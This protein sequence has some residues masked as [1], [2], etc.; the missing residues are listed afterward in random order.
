MATANVAHRTSGSRA[1]SCR[2][3]FT[4]LVDLKWHHTLLIF[5]MSFLCSCCSSPWPGGLLAFAHGDL[6][7][8]G[9]V[10]GAGPGAGGERGLRALRDQHPLL[11]LGLPLLHRGPGDHRLRRPHGD[12]GVPAGHPGP[13]RAEHRGADGQRHHAGLHLHEDRPGPPA[14]RDPHLQQARGH[15]RAPRPPL[16]HAAGGR[17]AQEHDHQRHHPHAG[18]PQDHQPRGRVVPLHQV[19]IPME[20]GVGGNSIFLVAPLIIYHVIDSS[21]PS[22]TWRRA[23]CTTTRTWRW[24]S[25]SRAWWRPR[26]SPPRPAPPTWPTRS[27]G[28]GASCPSWPRR[29]GATRSTYSK[30]GNTVKVPT[31]AC[32]ARQLEEN[33]SLLDTLPL[34]SPK[35]QLRK[36]SVAGARAKPRFSIAPDSS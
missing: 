4:T 30:F 7:R 35:S 9:P 36:R 25:S 24:S 5:T 21:S 26:A 11:R 12:R 10:A 22:T 16:L 3:V 15:R 19:D 32:T 1:A 31:P 34:T 28:A 33:R 2:N 6:D 14:G 27:S 18:G 8:H 23:T 29:T 13:H 17:P 20:N